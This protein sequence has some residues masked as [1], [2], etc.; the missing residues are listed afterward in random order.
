MMMMMTRVMCVL[1]VV[2]CCTCGYTLT[3]GVEAGSLEI[4]DGFP[5]SSEQEKKEALGLLCKHNVNATIDNFNCT[6]AIPPPVAAKPEASTIGRSPTGPEVISQREEL[7]VGEADPVNHVESA[8]NAASTSTGRTSHSDTTIT[9]AQELSAP[10][11]KTPTVT[12]TQSQNE[13][14][15]AESSTTSTAATDETT[16][17]STPAD[18]NLTQQPP[19]TA[20]SD[21]DETNSTI[22]PR[23]E[24]TTT[25]AP[26]TIPSPVP[27]TDPQISSI[28]STVQKKTNADSS[29]SPLWMHTA[30]PL[31]IVVVLFSATV[32]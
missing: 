27:V 26:T 21:S 12:S 16:D 30:A 24:N 7:E 22:P 23:T 9:A 3:V 6:D 8:S 31:L 19:V 18:S 29:V 2:L 25:E 13:K 15:T 32:Y 28:T 10:S 17:S 14:P 20:A 4:W 11:V 5:H 1:A